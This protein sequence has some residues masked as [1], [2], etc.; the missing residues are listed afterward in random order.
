[1]KILHVLSQTHLTGA[2]SYAHTLALNQTRMGHEVQIISD[3]WHS[4]SEVRV[5]SWPVHDLRGLNKFKQIF[6]LR[7]KIRA[8]NIDLIHTHSRAALRLANPARFGLPVAL[9]STVHGQQHFSWSKRLWAN[10]G[11]KIIAISE[12]IK[13]HL[14]Q[15][16][17]FDAKKISILRNPIEAPK[18][19]T[20]ANLG[21]LRISWVGRFTGP[22]GEKLSWLLREVMPKLLAQ[23][24][25]HFD[26]VGLGYDRWAHKD[27]WSTLHSLFPNQ[28]HLILDQTPLSS[29]W[30]NTDLVLGAG[31]TFVE[32]YLHGR[33]TL[34][35]GEAHYLGELRLHN[36]DNHMSS[37][38]GDL[39][40]KGLPEELDPEFILKDLQAHIQ[41]ARDLKSKGLPL[42][43]PEVESRL[44]SEYSVEGISRQ[45][46]RV[47]KSAVLLRRHPKFIPVLMYH[48]VL[49]E[50]PGPQ[51][52]RIFVTEK[53]FENHL[54]FFKKR[55]LRSL[56]F[57]TLEDF[58]SGQKAWSDFPK[59]PIIL[60]FDDGYRNNLE[61]ASPLL[62]KYD[63]RAVIF[64]LSDLGR[65][66]N[67]WDEGSQELLSKEDRKQVFGSFEIGSHGRSHKKITEMTPQ[68]KWQELTESK[69]NLELELKQEIISFAFTYGLKSEGDSKLVQQAGYLY[70]LNTD[71]GGRH[72][73]EDPFDIFRISIFPEESIFSLWKKTS[74]WYRTYYKW[75][76]RK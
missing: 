4:G 67:S 37:N 23:R 31:R 42:T 28:T 35:F 69:K 18:T 9:V 45:V 46:E 15:D 27:S 43:D 20:P 22:K 19:T 58:L 53:N 39:R 29:Y 21:P 5:E 61:L 74:P 73:G 64:L 10:Y 72:L 51:P 25:L 41:S 38:F 48:Q 36:I 17:C 3:R 33:K 32:S 56:T 6:R 2:E 16:F 24:D 14:V 59:K 62:K 13:N 52:H 12:S 30:K 8:E 49:K 60:T 11:E 7:R 47:Y 54:R 76:R 40:L 57:K 34:A 70:A 1:M 75:K 26:C 71:S 50:D 65:T 44:R 68:E 66:T 63:F 55:G